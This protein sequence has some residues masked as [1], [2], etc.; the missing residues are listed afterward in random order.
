M[1]KRAG[2]IYHRLTSSGVVKPV[3]VGPTRR[4]K[5]R[6]ASNPVIW[7]RRSK[8]ETAAKARREEEQRAAQKL[9]ES[10]RTIPNAASVIEVITLSAQRSRRLD[11]TGLY[12]RGATEP[13]ISTLRHIAEILARA[14]VMQFSADTLKLSRCSI[15]RLRGLFSML[16]QKESTSI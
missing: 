13:S 4:K 9:A 7:N 8:K 6:S 1:Y 5:R 11:L 2:K 10:L 15:D 16:T 14:G 3:R 12:A